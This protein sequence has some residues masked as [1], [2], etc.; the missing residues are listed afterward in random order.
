MV[1]R[2]FHLVTD[3]IAEADYFLVRMHETA[4]EPDAFRFN[5]SAFVSAARSTTFVLQNVM[6][7]VPGF[8][9]W[10][11]EQQAALKGDAVARF[12]VEARNNVL[13]TGVNSLFFG[14]WGGPGIEPQIF[15][16]LNLR[17]ALQGAMGRCYEKGENSQDVRNI[18]RT[19]L[20]TLLSVM[21]ECFVEF[22][23]FVDPLETYSP[24][25]LDV[26]EWSLEDVE[27]SFGYP[28]GYASAL[29]KSYDEMEHLLAFFASSCDEVPLNDFLTK[30]GLAAIPEL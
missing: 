5:Y 16:G 2:N 27:E 9:D 10:Y 11:A 17:H 6:R 26:N 18:A 30:Y 24:A 14:G 8:S 23:Y 29:C 15:W 19:Y 3:K 4:G 21:R 25:G 13:K 1:R 7:D 22:R 28:R 12:F 20:T